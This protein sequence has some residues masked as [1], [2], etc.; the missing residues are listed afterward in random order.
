MVNTPDRSSGSWFVLLPVPSHPDSR[1]SGLIG[2]RP[3]SQRRDREGLAPSSLTRASQC[4]GTLGE[5]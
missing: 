4:E 1:D 5:G 2:F 3:H